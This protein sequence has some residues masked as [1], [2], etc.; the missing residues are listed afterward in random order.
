LALADFLRSRP[1]D[2]ALSCTE[3]L[4][5]WLCRA[6]LPASS[7]CWVLA[8]CQSRLT[9]IAVMSS[10]SEFIGFIVIFIFPRPERPKSRDRSRQT[11]LRTKSSE[12][13]VHRPDE[14]DASDEVVSIPSTSRSVAIN[15]NDSVRVKPPEP[16]RASALSRP[17]FWMIAF[18]M[19]MCKSSVRSTSHRRFSKRLRFDVY[20]RIVHR[21]RTLTV[22]TS[23]T[24]LTPFL[25]LSTTTKIT[26]SS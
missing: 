7:L 4:P 1:W 25:T 22:R 17:D 2:C 21:C 16:V 18:I 19:S 12:S 23:A 9:T 14:D 3:L 6:I 24:V 13:L 5:K 15:N 8:L 10:L 11:L 20:K 26:L